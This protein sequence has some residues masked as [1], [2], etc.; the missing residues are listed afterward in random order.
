MMHSGFKRLRIAG[1]NKKQLGSTKADNFLTST[2]TINI[3]K[4]TLHYGIV[5]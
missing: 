3:S 5:Q 4:K 2:I 1:R